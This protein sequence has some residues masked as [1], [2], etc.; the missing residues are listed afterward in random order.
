MSR[1]RE[2]LHHVS[3][4]LH[5]EAGSTSWFFER[6]SSQLDECLQYKTF[7]IASIYQSHTSRTHQ[8]SSM[9]AWCVLDE[10]LTSY[11]TAIYTLELAW[12]ALDEVLAVCLA[13]IQYAIPFRRTVQERAVKERDKEFVWGGRS[14]GGKGC[15]AEQNST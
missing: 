11:V 9:C 10:C 14:W 1:C 2:F 4:S 6:L 3:T 5:D 12:W 8:A 13:S 15:C 7:H